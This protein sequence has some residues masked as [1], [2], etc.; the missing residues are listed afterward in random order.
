MRSRLHYAEISSVLALDSL[1]A[2]KMLPVACLAVSRQKK[3]LAVSL[4]GK[5][6]D[7]MV[8]VVSGKREQDAKVNGSFGQN[9]KNFMGMGG[10]Q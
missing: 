9:I 5:G 8:N 6:R 2:L 3:R 7:D 10:Q 4:D 1:V